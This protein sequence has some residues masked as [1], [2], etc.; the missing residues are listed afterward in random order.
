MY[1]NDAYHDFEELLSK[2]DAIDIKYTDSSETENGGEYVA[3]IRYEDGYKQFTS[4]IKSD[5][6]KHDK[7]TD[8]ET[9]IKYTDYGLKQ[10]SFI[11][12]NDEIS[13]ILISVEYKNND[14]NDSLEES[15][16]KV[17]PI[18][19]FYS[20]WDYD[21]E[22]LSAIYG[23]NANELIQRTIDNAG[24]YSDEFES[25]D[26]DEE[27]IIVE[28]IEDAWDYSDDELANIYGGDSNNSNWDD[29]NEVDIC[30]PRIE[31]TKYASI[32]GYDIYKGV[33]NFNTDVYYV[34]V[35]NSNNIDTDTAEIIC[36]D[37]DAVYDYIEENP[38]HENHTP[39]P[40]EEIIEWDDDVFDDTYDN[41]EPIVEKAKA[42][43]SKMTYKGQPIKNH[44]W[45]E[46]KRGE[47]VEVINPYNNRNLD[48]KTKVSG[49]G[50]LVGKVKETYV[51]QD[52]ADNLTDA[53]RNSNHNYGELDPSAEQS[54]LI[55]VHDDF[56]I[57]QHGNKTSNIIIPVSCLKEIDEKTY[58]EV[59]NKIPR[60]GLNK[61]FNK[62]KKRIESKNNDVVIENW[63][64]NWVEPT[65]DVDNP[66]EERNG[67]KIYKGTDQYGEEAYY[68]FPDYDP[69]PE[70]G[71]EEWQ[72]ETLELAQEWADS[73][74]E[75]D[76]WDITGYDN[77]DLDESLSDDIEIINKDIKNESESSLSLN[78]SIEHRIYTALENIAFVAN[79][80]DDAEED[81]G[82]EDL[83]QSIEIIEE[84]LKVLKTIRDEVVKTR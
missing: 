16:S 46:F 3:T 35:G 40:N 66:I 74:E 62:N 29:E 68:L 42:N 6:E 7:E 37:L 24:D 4:N 75:P 43:A 17:K 58:K 28:Y 79:E 8:G 1:K 59:I 13:R 61:L 80:Y 67:L 48:I 21:D 9:Y 81:L 31:N 82:L 54:C 27:D 36:D 14:D 32:D 77:C 63:Q 18:K 47:Y 52:G 2:F 5:W 20:D 45:A 23:A 51:Y 26:E 55:T 84:N 65:I 57:S 70:P 69:M 64:D 53:R 25:I 71:Y 49:Y 56:K 72:A 12:E 50:R 34:F 15:C 39:N 44:E 19:E 41:G 38:L 10:I 83:K 78:E 30:N 33:D 22:E 60:K 11:F 76:D 73:Y